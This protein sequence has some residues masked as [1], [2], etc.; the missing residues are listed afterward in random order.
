MRE[1]QQSTESEQERFDRI[2]AEY[3]APP[4]CGFDDAEAQDFEIEL[5]RSYA[6]YA[7]KSHFQSKPNHPTTK[8]KKSL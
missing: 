8:D 7:L 1:K 5:E 6:E 2:E 4:D 3:L